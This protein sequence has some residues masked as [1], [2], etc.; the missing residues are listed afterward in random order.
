VSDEKTQAPRVG[1]IGR[2]AIH[3]KMITKEQL[4]RCLREQN[5]KVPPD[6][7]GQVLLEGGYINQSQLDQLLKK[8]DELNKRS[9][10]KGPAREAPA[11]AASAAP[12]RPVAPA[13]T[14]LRESP[15]S[16]SGIPGALWSLLRDA[17]RVGAS[18]VHFQAGSKPFIRRMGRIQMVGTEPLGSDVVIQ[19]IEA[20]LDDAKIKALQTDGQVDGGWDVGDGLRCRY[21]CFE[22]VRGPGVVLRLVPMSIPTLEELGLPSILA[23]LTG[24]HQGLVLITGP[25]GCGKSSTVAALI[26]LMNEERKENIL[27]LEDPTEFVYR[28]HACNILQRQIP[29]HSTS[30]ASALRAALREDPDV[31]V[32]GEMRDLE[33]VSLALSAAETGH[34]VLGT[35]HTRDVA[36][37]VERV[38]G[39]FPPDQQGQVRSMLSESLRGVVSQKLLRRAEGKGRVPAVEILFNNHAVGNLIR[40]N[41]TFQLG[42]ILQMSHSQGM[43]SMKDSL[44]RLQADG[45]VTR[46]EVARA[47]A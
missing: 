17:Q 1:L 35:M 22:G 42:N 25:A 29:D 12:P 33:T 30:Y 40:D 46:K 39:I 41:R 47:L 2:L 23:R 43:C 38:I 34:L 37:T 11:A 21:N 44:A 26:Q 15:P 19:L 6:R 16:R 5:M 31:I 28:P 8:Q 24:F 45:L 14:P 36:G 7:L 20:M 3:F 27:V 18:D 13:R 9:A 4:L 32:I 10:D